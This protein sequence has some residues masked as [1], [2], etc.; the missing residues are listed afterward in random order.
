MYDELYIDMKDLMGGD[1][2]GT[3]VYIDGRN[4][5]IRNITN[6]KNEIY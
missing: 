2:I 1:I 5:T 6:V 4:L 3:D